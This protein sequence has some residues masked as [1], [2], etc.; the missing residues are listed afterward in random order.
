MILYWCAG[1]RGLPGPS[2]SPGPIGPQ[3]PPGPSGKRG[4]K[5]TVGP[6]GPQGKRGS[7]GLPGSPGP[8][9]PFTKSTQREAS[10]SNGQ[11][12][13]KDLLVNC[14]MLSSNMAPSAEARHACI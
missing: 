9:G 2:G 8:A 13:G 3:G 10:P 11:Q 5:G 12:L 6:P 7:R 1:P 14:D 4:R